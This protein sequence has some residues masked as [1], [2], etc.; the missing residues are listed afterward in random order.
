LISADFGTINYYKN[1]GDAYAPV[2]TAQTGTANPFN[3]VVVG[4]RTTVALADIDG[5]G[6]LDAFIG[7]NDGTLKYYRN[8]GTAYSP[9]FTAVTGTSNPFNNVDVGQDSS[10]TLGD[11]DGDGD[12]DAFFGAFSGRHLHLLPKRWSA[13]TPLSAVSGT[14]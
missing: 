1:T 14:G 8:D 3:G 11:V 12:L 2:F 4:S 7:L 6:D 10:V 9:T 13:I 5:D